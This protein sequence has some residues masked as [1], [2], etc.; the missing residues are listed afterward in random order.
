MKKTIFSLIL[1]LFLVGCLPKYEPIDVLIAGKELITLDFNCT[2]NSPAV[3]F[4]GERYNGCV[5]ALELIYCKSY[6]TERNY[7]MVCSEEHYEKI[8]TFCIRK[9]N[10]CL[11]WWSKEIGRRFNRFED[12]NECVLAYKKDYNKYLT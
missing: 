4:C 12:P 3:H 2:E 6:E 1:L 11:G 7:S 10:E 9:T 5:D 8:K